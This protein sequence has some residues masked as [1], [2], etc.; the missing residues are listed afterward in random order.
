MKA[1]EN[2]LYSQKKAGVPACF[3]Y[4]EADFTKE[5][6]VQTVNT[7]GNYMVSQLTSKGITPKTVGIAVTVQDNMVY[8]MCIVAN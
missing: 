3:A 4:K 6:V 1:I 7:Y 8:V 5:N 2:S